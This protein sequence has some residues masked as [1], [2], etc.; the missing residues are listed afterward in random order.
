MA[1]FGG[2]TGSAVA[3]ELMIGLRARQICARMFCTLPFG[4][5]GESRLRAATPAVERLSSVSIVPHVLRNDSLL[6]GARGKTM[7]AVM[8]EGNRRQVRAIHRFLVT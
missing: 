4:F 7:A 8:V 5:E 3:P 6:Y 1:G 2:A